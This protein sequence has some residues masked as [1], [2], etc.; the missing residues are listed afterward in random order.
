MALWG[1]KS[2]DKAEPPAAANN[3]AAAQAAPG[4]AQPVELSAAE[5]QKRAEQS[6]RT[7][8][9]FG[10]VVSVLM[11]SEPFRTLPIA[12]LETLVV[13]PLK[14][15]QAVVAE[16][17]SKSQ[18]FVTPV[19]AVLWARVSPAVDAKLSQNLDKPV[20]LTAD[21]WTSGDIPWI[22]AAAGEQK[23]IAPMIKGLVKGA[24]GGTPIKSRTTG[25]DGK[26]GIVAFTADEASAA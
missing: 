23:L 10:E 13:P 21:E 5:Q 4:G 14:A 6:A 9:K 3:G 17:R 15:G 11:R 12:A 2:T 7:L 24:L 18:G 20:Q 19:A 1:K 22:I 26:P 25:R 16:A 8:M